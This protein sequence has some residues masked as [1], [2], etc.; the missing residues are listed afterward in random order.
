[1]FQASNIAGT[2]KSLL[3]LAPIPVFMVYD[4][5]NQKLDAIKVF[6]CI[7]EA[8]D[9]N[10]PYLKHCGNVLPAAMVKYR[11]NAPTLHC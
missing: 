11:K 3:K 9:Y 10:L 8:E 4:C 5:L 1:M 2:T 6:D 7:K